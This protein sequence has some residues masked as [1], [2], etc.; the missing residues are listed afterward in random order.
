MI[1]NP[2]KIEAR[3]KCWPVASCSQIAFCA[4]KSDSTGTV[5]SRTSRQVNS[6]TNTLI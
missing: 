3:Q 6:Q 4:Q 5:G 2:P 1:D